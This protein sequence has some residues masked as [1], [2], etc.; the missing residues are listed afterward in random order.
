MKARG[1]R[2]S[3]R[4]FLASSAAVVSSLTL[5]C[6]DGMATTDPAS[7]S[8][9]L[10]EPAASGIE[11]VIVVM[12]E[13]RSFDHFAG[14][15]PG[16]D[17]RQ[18]GLSYADTTG[19]LHQTH[20][21]APDF[22]G[23]G[24]RDP[25]H[26]YAGARIEYNG[27]V[28]DGWL[29]VNDVYS[30]GYYRREDLPFFGKAAPGWT[31]FDRYFSA[32]MGPTTPNRLYQHAAQTDRIINMPNISTLPTIWDRLASRG[33]QGRYYF[34]YAPF[35]TLWGAKYLPISRSLDS[36]Y[37][38]CAA[39]TLPAV[40]FVDPPVDPSTRTGQD[41]HP[42]ND[43][44]LGDTFLNQIY[45][46]VTRGPAWPR[47]V[48]IINFDE[49]G[50]FFDH[51]PPPAAPIPEADLTAGSTDGLRGFR[52]PMVLISPFARRGYTSHVVYDHTSVLRLIEWR[53]DLQPLTVRDA[54]ANN[55]AYELDFVRADVDAPAYEMPPVTGAAC[56][57]QP[58][59]TSVGSPT[60]PASGR[61]DWAAALRDVARRHGWPV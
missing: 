15:L 48:L 27:G 18:A 58:L 43:V 52:T 10:P 12:M 29:R 34:G 11:H 7:L 32:F 5:G 30:L 8:G 17:G 60:R 44:R 31:S 47:T 54:T 39:G 61:A 41:D 6:L 2:V 59:D 9:H 50:G 42:F 37:A 55:L 25:D 57:T 3:R 53:W 33:L 36:F 19:A 16:A 14:W 56:S 35:L 46:A 22:Q 20:A 51:V 38:D 40:A 49:W 21:L 4:A 26:S 45:G 1:T 23:C 28:C 13:N 24:Y